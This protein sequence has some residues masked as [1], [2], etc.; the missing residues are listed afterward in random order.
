MI[1]AIDRIIRMRYLIRYDSVMTKKRA[2]ILLAG[3]VLICAVPFI[4]KVVPSLRSFHTTFTTAMGIFH[5]ALIFIGCALY[6]CAFC[7][8][9]RTVDRLNINDGRGTRQKTTELESR[10]NKEMSTSTNDISKGE[11]PCKDYRPGSNIEPILDMQ[12]SNITKSSNNVGDKNASIEI[13]SMGSSRDPCGINLLEHISSEP[14]AMHGSKFTGAKEYS[15][16]AKRSN[17]VGNK[18]ASIEIVS[19]GSSRDP[20]GINLREHISSEALTMY[21]NKS[22]RTKEYSNITKRSNNICNKNE[23][24]TTE[25]SIEIVSKGSSRDPC[26]I[27]LHEDNSNVTNP[28]GIHDVVQEGKT[29]VYPIE[30]IRMVPS[31]DPGG[32]TM[33]EDNR[34]GNHV[35]KW[36]VHANENVHNHTTKRTHRAPVFKPE[37]RLENR[38]ASTYSTY[39]NSSMNGSQK[40]N[41]LTTNQFEKDS[42]NRQ[43]NTYAK[44]SSNG[45]LKHANPPTNEPK[46]DAIR[47]HKLIQN[48]DGEQKI[49]S[50][51]TTTAQQN[52]RRRTYREFAK[53]VFLIVIALFICY[54]PALALHFNGD[55]E[56]VKYGLSSYRE[57][58]VDLMVQLNSSL[59]AV[60]FITCNTELRMYAK[61]VLTRIISS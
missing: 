50:N 57:Y 32:M 56:D 11:V 3:N 7:S 30:I 53:A 28:C 19:M 22:T 23:A 9:K 25:Y 61:S 37:W 5:L 14:L 36:H 10:P 55:A 49:R 52:M 47:S 12:Y 4:V 34:K 43:R 35:R 38:Q 60:I 29:K 8:M 48:Q 13:V 24:K 33:P 18:N 20:C 59:N 40:H 46:Q 6:I 26:G 16:I 54:I 2:N 21:D 41:T 27:N 44:S 31:P 15:S 58:W 45:K 51:T 42:E 17:N 1:I 39:A